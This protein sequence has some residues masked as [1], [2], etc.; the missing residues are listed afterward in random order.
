MNLL[1]PPQWFLMLRVGV[2]MRRPVEVT[3]RRGKPQ[4]HNEL[5]T[6]ALSV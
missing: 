3:M 5:H 4:R 1:P 2:V 6:A